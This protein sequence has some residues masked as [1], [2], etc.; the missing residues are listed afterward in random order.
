[1]LITIIRDGRIRKEDRLATNR[2]ELQ[3]AMQEYMAALDAAIL[4]ADDFPAPLRQTAVDRWVAKEVRATVIEVFL[5]LIYR[6]LKR[7]LC[8][9]APAG[10]R[11]RP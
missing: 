1:M 6:L 5:H 8:R 10:L 3:L 2:R 4:E 7:T 9:P 11:R